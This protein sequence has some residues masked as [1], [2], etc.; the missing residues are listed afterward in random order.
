MLT[1]LLLHSEIWG[2]LTL[3]LRGF[4]NYELLVSGFRRI[5]R[6][7][8][9]FEPEIV[10]I[11]IWVSGTTTMRYSISNFSIVELRFTVLELLV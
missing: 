6:V 8:L 7:F 1:M 4:Q 5:F 11:C 10:N 3:G 2:F 9:T